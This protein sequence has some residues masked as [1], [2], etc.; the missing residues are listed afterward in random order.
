M[1]E[2]KHRYPL[3]LHLAV[4]L[5]SC[6][7]GG[8]GVIGYIVYGSDTPQIVTENLPPGPLVTV[9]KVLLCLAVL[10]TYPL[11]LF[12]I[13][14]VIESYIFKDPQEPVRGSEVENV[15]PEAQPSINGGDDKELTDSASTQQDSIMTDVGCV[16]II[17]E[18][19]ELLSTTGDK[20][21]K[22]KKVCSLSQCD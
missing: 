16:P 11:Q 7:L 5:V 21:K 8:F 6:I 22:P 13:T 17:D 18:T 12:P 10:L 14:E 4:G 15:D 1:G 2:N 3:Y 20:F 9:V 19:T